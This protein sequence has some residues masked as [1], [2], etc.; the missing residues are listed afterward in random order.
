MRISEQWLR[1]W[2]DPAIDSEALCERLTLAGL[3]VDAVR[4]AAPAFDG[5]RVAR[6]ESVEPHPD[7]ERLH[8]CRV[9]AGEGHLRTIVCGAANAAAG[10]HAPLA[11]EGATLPGERRVEATDVRGVA[12]AGMLCSGFELGLAEEAGDG[13]LDLGPDAPLGADLF[14]WAGLDDRIIELELTPNRGDCL[15]LR[16]VARE[17][18]AACGGEPAGPVWRRVEAATDDRLDVALDAPRACPRYAG[19]VLRGVD[20]GAPSPF[21]LVE[22]LRRAGIRSRGPVVDVTNHVMLELGQPMHAFDLARLDG[23]IRVRFAEAG[24]RLELLDGRRVRLDPDTLVIADTS[25]PV[26][27][28]GIMGGGPSAVGRDSTELFLESACFLPAAMAGRARRYAAHTDSSHRFERGVDPELA[29]VAIERATA[30]ILAICGGRPGPTTDARAEAHLPRRVPIHLRRSRLERLL[31]YSPGDQRISAIL[32]ALGMHVDAVSDGWS[33]TPP[34]WRFDLAIEADLIEEIARV[35][36]YNRAPRTHPVAAPRIDPSPENKRSVEE[37]RDI[38]VSRSY[39]EAITYSFV[40]QDLQA[41]LQPGA[42]APTLSNPIASDM[43]VMRT[44]LWPGL[45][46]ALRHNLNRQQERVRLFEVGM[47]FSLEGDQVRQRDFIA[48]LAAGPLDA[49][50]WAAERRPVDFFDV[51]GDVE[52]LLAGLGD[53]R[54]E[55][56]AEPHPALHPGQSAAIRVDGRPAGWLGALHPRL[57]ARLELGAAPVL[58]ELPV[59]ALLETGLPNHEPV[60]RYPSIR[61]DLALIVDEDISARALLESVRRAA[62]AELR[63]AF[64]F[65]VYRGKGVDSGRK[66]FALGLILQG[67]ERTLTDHEVETSVGGILRQLRSDVDAT[68]R[69]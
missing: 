62:P 64:I 33:A 12:S 35:H 59:E 43:A 28:A 69:E 10:L 4:P 3:E 47:A 51:K 13:L 5:V 58:F 65:D 30:L 34:S 16:G 18:A 63:E 21:W 37:L 17:V 15:S 39:H 31:G 53:G 9:D 68:L 45:V 24:E 19:R 55:F 1:A 22:R 25:G 61:R 41:L 67:F 2:I 27:L 20:A 54:H 11:V 66:S 56:V 60:S 26:A 44:S 52:S 7:A 36:G 23:G 29:P 6:I 50:H 32:E 57:Q 14:A 38:L 8:V 40:D 46:S 42:S 48:G 49:E